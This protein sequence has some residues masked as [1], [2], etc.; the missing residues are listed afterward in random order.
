MSEAARKI[1]IHFDHDRV[2]GPVFEVTP[3]RLAAAL[4]RH[5]DVAPHLEITTSFDCQGMEEALPT[6]EALFVWRFDPKG[7]ARRAPRLRWVHLP[8]AGIEHLA[9]FDWL[10]SGVTL[11]NNRGVHGA[12]A[13]EYAI[14]A[15]LMLNNR[16]PEMVT[17]QRAARW[18]QVFNTGI[19]GKT[20][21]VIGVGNVGGGVARLAKL[22]GMRTLG[23]RRSGAPHPHIDEMHSPAALAALV[24]RADYIIMTAPSTAASRQL[25]G[26]REIGLMRN[27]SGLVNYSRAGLV[28]YDA[29]AERLERRE[30][31]AVLDAFD[32]EPLP[33]GSRLWRLPN[34]IVTPHCSS[35]DPQDYTPRTLDLV[36]DNL[37]RLIAGAPLRNVV[38]PR[39]E[40]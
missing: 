25:M 9:P 40:Y 33:P 20:L 39:L 24:P 8:G 5:P 37:R 14:M 2:L 27:G 7:L 10:P 32:P 21:L 26:R 35:D 36:F 17:N 31:S 1:H 22:F 38:D 34:L 3:E 30:I 15:V 11:T 18:E 16:V 28:D 23:V 4:A 12:R 6:T 19:A 29:L 13:D